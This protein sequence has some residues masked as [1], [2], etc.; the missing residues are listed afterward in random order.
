MKNVAFF[1]DGFN[2]YHSVDNNFK[3]NAYKWLDLRTLSERFIADNEKIKN[4]LYFSA[5]CTWDAR[6]KAKH[7]KYVRA[8][9]SRGVEIILGQ[10]QWVSKR[11]LKAKM[12][13]L[14]QKPPSAKLPDLIEFKSHEEKKTDVNIA[15]K[16]IELATHGE[17]DTFYI[18][19]GD[20]DF[21]PA[22]KY[23]KRYHRNI[24]LINILPYGAKGFKLAQVCDKQLQIT[25]K[26]LK[27]SL[28]PDEIKI[29]KESIK[30]P[31][32]YK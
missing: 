18:I 25:E 24:K 27:N 4:I 3:S 29:G 13:V 8:I 30:K 32:S 11:F 16:M 26:D 12:D 28:L 21:V 14:N 9:S 15:V 23:I 10:F 19:S 17:F 31:S 5:Y 7:K 1:I 6:K 2:V 20:T 22:I